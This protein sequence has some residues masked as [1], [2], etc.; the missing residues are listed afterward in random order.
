MKRIAGVVA[1]L[2][3]SAG[4]AIAEDKATEFTFNQYTVFRA[5]PAA[6]YY[7]PGSLIF[8]YSSRGVLRVEM[9]CQNRVDPEKTD[10]ILKAPVE[11]F[12]LTGQSGWQFDIGATA[13]T[14]LNAAFKGNFVDSVTMSIS[15]VTVYEY[16]AEDLREVRE[17]ILARPGCAAVLKNQRYRTREF[18]GAPSGI[19]QNQRYVI[20]DVTYT[21]NFNKDNPK[22]FEANVQAQ[23]TKTFQAK[24]GL[25]YL[26]ASTT[27]LKGSRVVVGVF[28][29]WRNL[30]DKN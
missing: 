21:V 17:K 8:G 5:L 20:G 11:Q 12:G 3:A 6:T 30:W 9:V 7:T 27:E 23:I 29:I 25:S 28:P 10:A 19:F 4:A 2:F 26:N 14:T 18:N 1:A 15:N 13:S 22:A 24:F 16:S